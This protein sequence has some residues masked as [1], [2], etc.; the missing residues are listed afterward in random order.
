M[1]RYI[2]GASRLLFGFIKSTLANIWG[3]VCIELF[4]TLDPS[5]E[6][7]IEKG[8]KCTIG[9]GWNARSGS[10]FRV[11]K[12]AEVSIG[13]NFN[14]STR[15]IVTVRESLTIGDN[16]TFGPGVLVYDHDHDYKAP[17]GVK[18]G[19]Y[20]ASPIKIGNNVW[21]GAG[22]II[23]RGAEIADNSVV[24]AGT[25]VRGSFAENSLIYQQ[26]ETMVKSIK[27]GEMLL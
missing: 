17:G 22:S 19:K 12:G 8:A 18:S 9:K 24:A 2:G 13:K 23:L 11:R 21:I 6:V 20:K 4:N 1:N 25:V 15:S 27:M 14:L 26:R 10:I 7:T 5:V 16:V 3:G